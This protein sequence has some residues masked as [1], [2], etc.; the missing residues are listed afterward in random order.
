MAEIAITCEGLWK[1]YRIHNQRAHTLREKLLKGQSRFEQFWALRG[2]DLEIRAGS[3]TGIIGQNGCGK[4]TLLKTMA[5]VHTPN[6]GRVA[7]TGSVSPLLELGTGF[8]PDLTGRE[9]LYMGGSVL[10]QRRRDIDARFDDIVSF[11]DIGDF[12]DSPIKNYSSGMYARLAFALAINVDADI[13]LI[14][15]VLAV[16]DE[17]FQLRC[18]DRIGKLRAEGRTI[19]IVTHALDAVRTLCQQAAW[20]DDGV[21]RK[22]GEA[23]DVIAGYLTDVHGAVSAA[24]DDGDHE[25]ARFGSGEAVITS[26]AFLGGDGEA[27]GAFRTGTPMT[28]RIEYSVEERVDDLSCA[29]AVYRTE[30]L[31]Y[32]FGQST[33][34]AGVD[35]APTGAGT[36][37]LTIPELPLLQGSY[38]VTLA[39]HHRAMRKIY[40][41]HERRYS[42]MVVLDPAMPVEAGTVHVASEWKASP[43]PVAA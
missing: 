30:N 24:T 5:G 16:G 36:V 31:A 18:Y 20:M 25:G 42:F 8:H 10:G 28:V 14:D 19:V 4:S 38:V 40:D 37:E 29:I 13:I 6:K 34:A 12:I 3:T 26:V 1:S 21:V 7:V 32:V 9:N 17:A 43:P 22:A 2:I 33:K 11:A 39:L 15:E 35:L 23:N 41:Y 27:A